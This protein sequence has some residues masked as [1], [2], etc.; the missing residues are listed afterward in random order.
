MFAA[1]GTGWDI[2]RATYGSGNS[3]VDVTER[4]RS[5]VQNDMLNF[6]VGRDTLGQTGQWGRNRILRLQLRDARG[7]NRLVIYRD[8]QQVNLQVNTTYLSRLR[9]NRATY[10][11]GYRSADVTARLNSQIQGNQLNLRVNNDTMG[12]DPAP[13]QSKTLTVAYALD[14]RTN[15]VVIN[16]GDMLRL[17]N[18][19]GTNTGRLQITRAVY[20]VGS[21]WADVTNRLNSQIQG[22]QLR[23]DVNNDTM[24]GDP[25]QN[26]SKTLRVDY[27]FD[28]RT[29]QVAVNEGD[30]LQLNSGT[31]NSRLQITRAIYGAGYRNSDVTA[32]L[33]SQIR[34]DQLNLQVNNDTMGGDPAQNQSKT[35]RVDYTIDGRTGQ[36][37]VNEGDTLR[38]NSGTSNN[39]G[40]LQITRATYGS[41]YRNSDV[42]ARLNSQIRGDQLNLQ[43]NNDTMGGDP[44][45][46][47]SKTL[48]VAYALNGRTNQVVINEGDMLRL[49]FGDTSNN[50]GSLQITRA[51]YGAGYRNSDVT[52]RLNS[53]I[54]NDQLNLQVNNDT[55]GGDPAPN[56]AKTLTV[57]Y[58]LNGRTNQVVINEGDMLRLPSSNTS[59]LSQRVRCESTEASGY[60]RNYCRADT[61]GG[62][63]LSRKLSDSECVQGSGW[64]YDAG[65]VWVDRGCSADFE[66]GN[67]VSSGASTT[68]PSGTELSV[69][70]N[71]VI[72]SKTAE[73]G[74]TY[75]AVIVN[76]VRDGFGMVTI[77]R[78][79]DAELVIR[80]ADG[81]SVA[82]SSDLVIDMNSVTV[83]GTRYMVSTNDLEQRGGTGVGANRRTAIMVGGGAAL[84]TL[85]GALAGGAKG[86]AIGAAAGAGAG[87]G[88]QILTRGKQV[89]VPAE[90]VLNFRL[91]QDVRFQALR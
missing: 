45:P 19:T 70:T 46:N 34:G 15:Q 52:A 20:G 59:Q 91:D 89:R 22:N 14:S 21:R 65:G 61:R 7:N 41:G 60:Q 82:S 40:S 84:G 33:N 1:P 32:R 8:R 72:D 3:W 29:N 43:V 77:P 39:N 68:I 55:M 26:Q 31:S 66:T 10:G 13:N 5:L 30:T 54:R 47:Q 23:M 6:S 50:N 69:R 79:S 37:A 85:I 64:G 25:A 27:T 42:T 44:A 73:A 18:S 90:T 35:L 4:V 83:A 12:G 17:N 81:G 86:A 49:P 63:R 71:E 51:T 87:L 62:V 36:V 88:A 58:T 48:T 57:A 78:G 28:G 24:G 67:G 53:Q 80:S 9:I 38:L 16:E 2:V 11:S 76:D 56:Q 74:Q 75:S